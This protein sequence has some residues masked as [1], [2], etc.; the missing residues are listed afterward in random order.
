MIFSVPSNILVTNTSIRSVALHAGNYLRGSG[1]PGNATVS[2]DRSTFSNLPRL[3][4]LSL[5]L[6]P[7]PGT[8][9]PVLPHSWLNPGSP[10]HRHLNSEDGTWNSWSYG[11]TLYARTPE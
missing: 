9:P 5:T 4:S 7:S 1:G 11:E 3:E 8:I 2:V 6:P 10:L